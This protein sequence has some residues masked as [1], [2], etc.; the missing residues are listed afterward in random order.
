IDS[1]FTM[2][3]DYERSLALDFLSEV[4]EQLL[5]AHETNEKFFRLLIAVVDFLRTGGAI[6]PAVLY[7]SLWAVRL[8]GFL[9]ELRVGPESAE[10][11]EEMFATAPG[12]LRA[13]EWSKT[14]AADLRRALIRAMEQQSERRYLTV[15]LLEAL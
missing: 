12:G 10:I 3:A 4:T 11:A 2:Q 15:P 14:T 7:F 13:R 6:W 8:G 9:P 5:P 1:P